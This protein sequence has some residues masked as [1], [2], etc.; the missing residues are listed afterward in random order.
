VAKDRYA[1]GRVLFV[2]KCTPTPDKD[3]GSIDIYNLMCI[4]IN[5]GWVVTFI[6]ED[7]YAFMEKYTP[8]LQRLGVHTLYYPYT[9]SVSEHVMQFGGHYDLVMLFRPQVVTKHIDAVRQHCTKAKVVYNTVD[10]HYLRMEREIDLTKDESL[11]VKASEMKKLERSLLDKVD[12]TTVVSSS[13]LELLKRDGAKSVIH[14]P[15]SR[16]VRPG[17]TPFEDRENILFVGGFNHPP[18]VD[19]VQYFVSE[20]MPL[21]RLAL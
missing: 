19:A 8:T 6:P 1:A 3:S 21:L 10:L 4:F 11:R 16:E 20:I 5:L 12:L 17:K 9:K 15:F 7:N 2:D 14:L 13:E 18:N